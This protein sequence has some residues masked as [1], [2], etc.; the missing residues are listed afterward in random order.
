M[1]SLTW[2]LAAP[3]A[4][5]VKIAV[6]VIKIALIDVKIV[7][8]VVQIAIIVVEV[9]IIVIAINVTAVI[10]I[11]VIAVGTATRKLGLRV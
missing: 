11:Y 7:V 5:S 4:G 8:I 10:V 1:P 2:H 6:I 3:G 9:A